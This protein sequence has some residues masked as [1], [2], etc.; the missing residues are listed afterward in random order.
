VERPT[1]M[2]RQPYANFGMLVGGVVFGDGMDQF[3]G[4]DGGF[5]GAEKTDE[6][7]V[8][9]RATAGFHSRMPHS[10]DDQMSPPMPRCT[11]LTVSIHQ[12][13]PSGAPQPNAGAA[14]GRTD[15]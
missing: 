1:R 11:E 9:T 10:L 13:W 15:C 8:A 2:P 4:W 12:L 5:D 6:L 3:A 7:L 14:Q